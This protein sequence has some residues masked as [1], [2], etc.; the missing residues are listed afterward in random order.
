M[1]VAFKLVCVHYENIGTLH[2]QAH[3]KGCCIYSCYMH[4]TVPV[5]ANKPTIRTQK[6]SCIQCTSLNI[7]T[8]SQ[9]LSRLVICHCV[10]LLS[11]RK[12]VQT[13]RWP[14]K[15]LII[16]LWYDKKVKL[17]SSGATFVAGEHLVLMNSEPSRLYASL[18]SFFTGLT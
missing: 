3:A 5:I 15:L 2:V 11:V 1:A 9:S 6:K 7:T 8:F 4:C 14:Q 17:T 18:W 16:M 13:L 10:H 12:C